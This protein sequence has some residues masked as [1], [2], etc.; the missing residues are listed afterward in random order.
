MKFSVISPVY[1]VSKY[2]GNLIKSLDNQTFKDFEL[3]LVNDGST[4]NSVEVAEDELKETKIRYT[5]LNKKNGG[6]SSARNLGIK[7]SKGDWI[8]IIDSDDVVQ[9]NYL[10]SF[11]KAIENSKCDVLICDI[12]R[13][14]DDNL[15]EE[16]DDEYSIEKDA[17]GEFYKRFFMHDIEI[18]PYCLCINRNYLLKEKLLYS[19]ESRYSEEFIFITNLLHDAK[20]VVHIKQKNYNY[21][22]RKGSVST[23]ANIEKITN[24]FTQINKYNSK[25]RECGCKYCDMYRKYAMARWIIATARFSSKNM[26]YKLYKRLLNELDYKKY[27]KSLKS[28]PK[29]NVRIA[30]RIMYTSLLLSYI[31]FKKVGRY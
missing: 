24:G 18:G 27:E 10:E 15:F 1:N 17:G 7:N 6:Q 28:F 8:V 23:S 20:S 4:D 2:I 14:T 16:T 22:L 29:R 13:V 25:F 5:I 9:S 30:A 12:N 19:E 31:V 11:N 3:I 21:C 26:S